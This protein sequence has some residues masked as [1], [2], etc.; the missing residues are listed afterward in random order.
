[1]ARQPPRAHLR[2]LEYQDT[3]RG[4]E[5]VWVAKCGAS[6]REGSAGRVILVARRDHVTCKRCLR[7]LA[8][9]PRPAPWCRSRTGAEALAMVPP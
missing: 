9:G 6:Q 8:P 2:Q 3:Y 7:L 4:T 1:M 5:E